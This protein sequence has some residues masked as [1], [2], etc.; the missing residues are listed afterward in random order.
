VAHKRRSFS[1]KSPSY[2]F[3]QDRQVPLDL[4]GVSQRSK[5]G[6]IDWDLPVPRVSSE[7]LEI[8]KIVISRRSTVCDRFE[9]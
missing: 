2:V 6:I 1:H 7:S 5:E 4:S 3:I 8:V 9:C